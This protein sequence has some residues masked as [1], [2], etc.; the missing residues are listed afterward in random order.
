MNEERK[1]TSWL[2]IAVI[3]VVA[4]TALVVT[5]LAST[6]PQMDDPMPNP[7]ATAQNALPGILPSASPMPD[8]ATPG[9]RTANASAI[10]YAGPVLVRLTLDAD[11]SIAQLDVGGARFQETEG[12]GSRVKDESHVSSFI[13]K[14][15]P[16]TL[17]ETADAVAGA[18]LSSQA[19]VDAINDAAA[20]LT[21]APDDMK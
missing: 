9:R 4:G 19:M 13:G 21:E 12:V 17:G 8:A 5:T 2:L 16:L 3:V 15:P 18:T 14:K 20:F 11:G 10:G 1:W 7:T 6:Q